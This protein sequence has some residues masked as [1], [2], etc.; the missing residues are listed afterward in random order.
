MTDDGGMSLREAWHTISPQ[1]DSDHGPLP[2]MLVLLTLGSGLVDAFSYLA[3]GHV[4]VANMTGN[5]VFLGFA[6]AGVGEFDVW[7][8]LLGL[9]AFTGGAVL[10]ARAMRRFAPHRGRMALVAMLVQLPVTVA[11]AIVGLAAPHPYAGL[12]AA[13]LIG[14]LAAA[15]GFQNAAVRALGVPDLTTTVLTRTLTAIAAESRWAGGPGGRSGRRMVSILSM[16]AGAFAGALL[17]DRGHPDWV[18][19]VASI[20]L[21]FVA[22]TAVR[23]ARSTQR[24]VSAHVA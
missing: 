22:V 13:V 18:L 23:A 12:P 9:T 4:F 5:V 20:V 14:V 19:V 6:L 11:A 7:R 15:L 21:A 8:S 10:S 1:P 3:L 24:W 17:V 16:F 2:P